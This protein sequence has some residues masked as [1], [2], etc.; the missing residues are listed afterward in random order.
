M[1]GEA[2]EFV[3][4]DKTKQFDFNVL[5]IDLFIQDGLMEHK[6]SAMCGADGTNICWIYYLPNSWRS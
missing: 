6:H 4:Q 2:G 5:L 3:Q 1:R